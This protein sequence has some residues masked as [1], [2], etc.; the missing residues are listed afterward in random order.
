M[1]EF[2]K[3]FEGL[4]KIWKTQTE[5]KAQAKDILKVM[6]PRFTLKMFSCYGKRMGLLLK[7]NRNLMIY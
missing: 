3:T 4:E 5:S 6:E 7:I 1:F 2:V